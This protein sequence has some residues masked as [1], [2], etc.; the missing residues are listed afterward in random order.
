MAG[1]Y[2][3]IVIGG[4]AAGMMAAGKAASRGR[5]V[6]LIEKNKRLGEKLRITGGGRCN[7]TN[8]EEDV[9]LLLKH[10][11]QDKRFLHS[12]FAQFG[13]SEALTFFSGLDL[14]TVVQAGKRA[15]PSSEKAIDVVRA[16]ER[17]M[18]QGNVDIR[19]EA[20]VT[21]ILTDGNRLTGVRVN[22]TTVSAESYILATGGKS[23]PETGS[24]GD[25]FPWLEKLGHT[26]SEPT[27]T[28]VPITVSDPWVHMLAGTSL[29][30][31]KI[32]FFLQGKK[33]FFLR[34]RILCTHVGLSG[35]LIL[36]AARQ[37]SDL[38]HEGDVAA[39]IDLFPGQ[40]TGAVDRHITSV[41]DQNKNKVLGNVLK[42]IM[43]A[44]TTKSLNLLAL[45]LDLT[46]KVHS[47][48][49]TDR[50]QLVDLLKALP[51]HVTGLLGFERAVVVDGGVTTAEVDGKT[52]RS[53]IM[54]NLFVTGDIL[55]ISRPS[56]GYS[57]Q[58]C[59]T[60]G[61]VAGSYA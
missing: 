59:W 1:Q 56:G 6:L 23:H 38:L 18:K 17:Y 50:R 20:Q 19:T 32:T 11:G 27:P 25:G 60:T 51:V 12:S 42:V 5:R 29:N 8:A 14:P 9:Q 44:G 55:D 40:D 37:I 21:E 2:D 31:V 3:V 39:T 43:P 13:V 58:L 61:W 24:T 48:S 54:E 34:G 46:Q 15:F 16:L 30:D 7:I 57:L 35:P 36:N 33:N 26:V 53:R 45:H 47:V 10:Y 28:I 49:K 52:M 41:F 4:G 22:G